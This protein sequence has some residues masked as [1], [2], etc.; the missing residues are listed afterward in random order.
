MCNAAA[1]PRFAVNFE[2]TLVICP[3]ILSAYLVNSDI[4]FI[5]FS[6]ATAQPTQ[7]P[8]QH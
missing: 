3:H 4:L 8:T 5:Y 7:Q 1:V 2:P 6:I